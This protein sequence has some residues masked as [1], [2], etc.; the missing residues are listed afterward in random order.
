MVRSIEVCKGVLFS[1][2]KVCT[3]RVGA[4]TV[5]DE[6]FRPPDGG[7]VSQLADCTIQVGRHVVGV[8]CFL[9]F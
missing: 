4:R 3:I 8:V 2:L 7:A 9:S 5:S 1:R 6:S